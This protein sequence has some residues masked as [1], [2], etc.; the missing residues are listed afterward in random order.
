MIDSKHNIT[1]YPA[2][3][4]ITLSEAI[5]KSLADEVKRAIAPSLQVIHATVSIILEGAEAGRGSE[6]E[7]VIILTS[8][9]P[10]P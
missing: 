6:E 4:S 3:L 5:P 8:P 9:P 1:V 7:E 2:V 10:R